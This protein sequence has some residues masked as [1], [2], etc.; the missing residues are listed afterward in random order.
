VPI[1]T[2]LG[3]AYCKPLDPNAK[4]PEIFTKVYFDNE[5]HQKIK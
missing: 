2:D 1:L 4:Y 3:A 5:V